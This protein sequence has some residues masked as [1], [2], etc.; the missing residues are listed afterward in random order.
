[1]IPA[2]LDAVLTRELR[3]L[4]QPAL[5]ERFDAL[6]FLLSFMVE[7]DLYKIIESW[8]DIINLEQHA[9]WVCKLLM[10]AREH[11]KELRQITSPACL[12]WLETW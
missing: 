10:H 7:H 2:S 9:N 8:S 1:L 11:A 3:R 6:V 12:T 5:W 4:L